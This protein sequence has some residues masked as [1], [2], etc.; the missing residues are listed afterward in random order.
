MR[1]VRTLDRLLLS[2]PPNHSAT[3]D[4]WTGKVSVNVWEYVESLRNDNPNDKQYHGRVH[5]SL[6]KSEPEKSCCGVGEGKGSGGG[7]GNRAVVA[8][9]LVVVAA[10]AT[11][12]V[13]AARLVPLFQGVCWY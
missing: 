12:L 1:R 3:R 13:A 4:R 11:V 7:L 10:T 8:A 6:D 2:A 5:S 9:R